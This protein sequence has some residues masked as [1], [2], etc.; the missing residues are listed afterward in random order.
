MM[1]AL[2]A[3]VLVRDPK[4]SVQGTSGRSPD[5]S[6]Q[7]HLLLH[8]AKKKSI[9]IRYSGIPAISTAENVRIST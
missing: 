6:L 3:P 1:I 5:S 8:R 7:G 9:S 4:S 2:R